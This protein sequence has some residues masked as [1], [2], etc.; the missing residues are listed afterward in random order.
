MYLVY[1]SR[2]L[3]L[4]KSQYRQGFCFDLD[5][6]CL[7]MYIHL[8]ALYIMSTPL[9]SQFPQDRDQLYMKVHSGMYLFMSVYSGIIL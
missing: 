2:Q 7:H 9:K 8:I 5:I 3:A 4:M 6:H 1:L